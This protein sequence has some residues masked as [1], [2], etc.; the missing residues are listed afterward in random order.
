MK[1]KHCSFKLNSSFMWVWCVFFAFYCI[2]FRHVCF[3]FASLN[4]KQIFVCFQIK[5]LTKKTPLY[6]MFSN[7]DLKLNAT[8]GTFLKHYIV[9][10]L[11]WRLEVQPGLLQNPPVTLCDLSLQG[12]VT[13]L[14]HDCWTFA[15][16]LERNTRFQ[17]APHLDHVHLGATRED[18]VD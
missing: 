17:F 8:V 2:I 4:C 9:T 14:K 11:W 12:W 5:L 6:E 7:W 1:I 18:S 15:H 13:P 10:D 3:S 16:I